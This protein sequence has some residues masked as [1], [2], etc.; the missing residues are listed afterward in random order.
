MKWNNNTWNWMKKII[1]LKI[2]WNNKLNEIIINEGS[3]RSPKKKNNVN[4]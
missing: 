1:K 2:K 4:K 3:P